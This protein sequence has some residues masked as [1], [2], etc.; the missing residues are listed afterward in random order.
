[1]DES[2]QLLL[3]QHAYE[4]SAVGREAKRKALVERALTLCGHAR[5]A[6]LDSRHDALS[7]ACFELYDALIE[8]G[9]TQLAKQVAL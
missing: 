6:R 7:R 2:T 8:L 9:H 1:M 5:S 4:A 3:D